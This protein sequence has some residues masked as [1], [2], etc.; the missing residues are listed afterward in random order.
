MANTPDDKAANVKAALETYAGSKIDASPEQV[1]QAIGL[2]PFPFSSYSFTPPDPSFQGDNIGKVVSRTIVVLRPPVC[3][4]REIL[5]LSAFDRMPASG[6]ATFRINS[7]L[8]PDDVP[9]KRGL[10]YQEPAI[11]VATPESSAPV[12]VT[13][14][15]K[16]IEDPGF[17]LPTD[18]QIDLFTW[19]P[20]GKPDTTSVLV[21]W[22]CR[23]PLF[24]IIL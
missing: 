13:V 16:L 20:T 18:L 1:V 15:H 5:D 11:I 10:F 7:F 8:C 19:G 3:N 4:A 22:R 24:G 21:N 2:T 9:T 12:Y 23:I 17:T 6:H 14:T